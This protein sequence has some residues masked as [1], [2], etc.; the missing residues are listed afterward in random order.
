[1]LAPRMAPAPTSAIATATRSTRIVAQW[2]W[3]GTLVGVACG[4]ASA[5]F[6]ETLDLATATRLAHPSLLY[7]LPFAGFLIGLVYEHVGQPVRGGFGLILDA[8]HRGGPR[9]P[10]RMAPIALI[11]TVLTHLFGGSAG[12]EGTA[13]QMGGTLADA[14]AHAVGI[15]DV[16]RRSVIAAGISGGFASVFGTPIAGTVFGLEV[17]R[18]GRVEYDS[19]LPALVSAV[20]GDWVTRHIGIRH[21]PYPTI[22]ATPLTPALTVKWLVFG[23]AV[24]LTALVFVEL[25]HLVKKQLERRVSRISVRM[26]I[27]GAVVVCLAL[28]LRTDRYLGL[29]VPTI[30][31]AFSDR[32]I[33]LTAFGWKLVFTAVTVGAGFLG[34][35]VTPLFFVGATLGHALARPLGI[36]LDLAA[37]VAMATVFGAAA[38]TPLALSLMAV[39]L[40]GAAVLPHVVIVAVVAYLV[41]GHRGIYPAQRIHRDKL[42]AHPADAADAA[43]DR[44]LRDGPTTDAAARQPR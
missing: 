25:T 24:G 31:A 20:V 33:P 35:E 28:A 8:L 34:G 30:V 14:L 37:A 9:V 3:L 43:D 26:L 36:P 10:L 1:M 38:N 12:R 5:L 27:G 16:R 19:L 29:G 39:E 11:G 44:A 22:D 7:A 41:S 21:T 42:D 2:L 17:V 40:C 23:L 6:L 32:S 4:L 15:T 18:V 13:V